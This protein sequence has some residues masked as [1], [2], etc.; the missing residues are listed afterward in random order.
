MGN[1]RT[2][3]LYKVHTQWDLVCCRKA[4]ILRAG[5]TVGVLESEI[6]SLVLLRTQPLTVNLGKL[7]NMFYP[8][9][10]SV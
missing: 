9:V 8:Q 6:L 2:L 10:S 5:E 7:F 4:S 3:Y 1:Y